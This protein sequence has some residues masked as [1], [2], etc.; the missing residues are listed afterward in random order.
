M[1]TTLTDAL[2][3]VGLVDS[4]NAARRAIGDGGASL[5][6]V[7]ISDAEAV[8]GRRTSCT[9]RSPCCVAAARP[10]PPARRTR[11]SAAARS[12]LGTH[13]PPIR[14]GPSSH[15][16]RSF[17]LR[18]PLTCG[19]GIGANLPL[20]FSTSARQGGTDTTEVEAKAPLEAGRSRGR[21]LTP[22]TTVQAVTTALAPA[23]GWT[24][25]VTS[26][27][28]NTPKSGFGNGAY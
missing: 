2:V 22:K 21:L 3:A 1:G 5:N 11:T 8:L 6:N 20:L 26:P 25:S 18:R 14:R 19:F 17:S 13:G 24:F 9:D 15:P 10:S 16:G 12:G 7:K 4:R 28:P 27:A 23:P